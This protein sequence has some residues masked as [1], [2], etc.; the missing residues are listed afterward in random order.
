MTNQKIVIVLPTIRPESLDAFWDMWREQMSKYHASLAI[1]IDGEKPK[2]QYWGWHDKYGYSA[3]R[4]EEATLE[5]VMGKHKK[6]ISN[7]NSSVRNLG[8]VFAKM[9]GADVIVTLDDDTRP[10]GDTIGDHLKALNSDVPVS[11]IST[12][13]VKE[14]LSDYMRGFPYEVRQERPVML[15]HGVWQGV[16]DRDAMTQL[17]AGSHR[18]VEFYKGPIPKGILFPF[19]G[20]NV[21]FRIEALPFVYYAPVGQFKGAER[22]DDIWGGIPMKRDFDN[23]GYAIVSGY[24]S[25]R[26]ERASDPYKN[27]EREVIGIKENEYFW[28]GESTHPF[29]K[30]FEKKRKEWCEFIT[31]LDDDVDLGCNF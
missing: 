19:C 2:I 12:T 22:F 7:F 24:A 13:M 25:V 3:W 29:F 28:K 8:F 10:D 20:M 31:E 26:H 14:S 18:P 21:A 17:I 27:L 30:E 11:W 15:S 9:K 4:K 1:V 23:V 16:P 6:L 5:E